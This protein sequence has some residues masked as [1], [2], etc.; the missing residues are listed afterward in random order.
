MKQGQ[1]SQEQVVAMLQQAEEGEIAIEALCRDKG[2]TQADI[3]IDWTFGCKT[4]G[5]VSDTDLRLTCLDPVQCLNFQGH[6][7]AEHAIHCEQ[8]TRKPFKDYFA[9]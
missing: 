2:I 9:R 3:P 5:S 8:D 4:K 7:N 6:Y 1:F